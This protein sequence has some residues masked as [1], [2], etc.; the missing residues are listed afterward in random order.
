[1]TQAHENSIIRILSSA[2]IP[3]GT[4]FLISPNRA[5]TCAHV[6]AAVFGRNA[7]AEAPAGEFSLDFPLLAPG[8]GFVARVEAWDSG[9]DVAVLDITGE[10]PDGA[11]PARLV[12]SQDL[13]KHDFRAFGFPNGF[14]NGIWASGRILGREATGWY[15]VED[16]KQTGYFIQP[17]FSGGAVWDESLGGVIGMVMAADNREAIRAAFILPL[18]KIP[19]MLAQPT[20]S[21]DIGRL[22]K[23]GGTMDT[24]S[25]FYVERPEDAICQRDLARG[26]AT[27]V[28]MAPRQMGKSSMLVRATAQARQLGREVAFLDFQ[29]VDEEKLN[30]PQKF[31]QGFCRWI[32]D[33]LD[34]DLARSAGQADVVDEIWQGGLG[35]TQSCTKFLRRYALKGLEK[36]ITLVMD[37]VDRMLACPFR[38]DFFGMLRS[39]HNN[40]ATA[41]EWRK[42]DLLMVISTEPYLLIDD[43]KQSPFNVVEPLRL[44]DFNPAQTVGLN[45]R[46]G[47]PFNLNQME[48]LQTLLAGHPYLT[49]LALYRT[50]VG[51]IS[52]ETLFA[53]AFDDAGPFGDHLRRYLAWF[54]EHPEQARAMLTII[55]H[56]ICDDE[57]LYN[58]L[59]GAGLVIRQGDK[60]LPRCEL[61][62]GYFGKRLNHD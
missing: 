8:Q 46:H 10:L 12:Q 57:I 9:L 35:H 19:F 7:M 30:D 16:T 55:R 25:L 54:S 44:K 21:A 27:I 56:K 41:P 20:P 24:E 32:A 2:G 29:Q 61:Y 34:I 22:E 4:G 50:A 18:E 6:V 43:L 39:W 51:E 33:E 42:L 38:S 37:E 49:R 1:M 15:Q 53:T 17:G 28:I 3:V 47:V 60:T 45:D 23:P 11:Q 52:A 48:R 36:P 40:R 58:R 31:F 14:P 62:A 26:G 13:W 5:L 59:H